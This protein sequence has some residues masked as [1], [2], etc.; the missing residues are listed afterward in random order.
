MVIRRVEKRRFREM[1]KSIFV[2]I[3]LLVCL[4]CTVSTGVAG[5]PQMINF[6]G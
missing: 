2:F 5:V 1:K 6:Q 3:G 4:L